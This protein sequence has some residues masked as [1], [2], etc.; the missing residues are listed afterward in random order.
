LAQFYNAIYFM[1]ADAS[2]ATAVHIYDAGAKS[3]STQSVAASTFDPTSFN[4]ILDHDT[5][6]FY[7]LSKGE[8]FFLRME[9]LVKANDT[10]LSWVDVGK[11][12]LPD[13]YEPVM[14]LAENHIHFLDVPNIPAGD[15]NIFV[16][17]CK[18]YLAL[19]SLNILFTHA[20]TVSWYQPDPQSYPLPDG[21]TFPKTHGQATSFFQKEGVQQE[22]AFIPD[23]GSATYVINVDTNTTQKLPGPSTKDAAAQYVAG[24]TSLVQVD[25]QGAVSFL[26]YKQGDAST[27]AQASW[28]SVAN[29]AAAVP[30]GTAT[31]SP[32]SNSSSTHNGTSSSSGSNTTSAGGPAPSGNSSSSGGSGHASGAM[33]MNLPVSIAVA[34]SGILCSIAALL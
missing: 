22:F 9:A 1:N 8:L 19:S 10:A 4:A 7:A 2:D 30:A 32:G 34:V 14:A 20:S 5:N 31:S 29:L 28:T 24:I 6:V 3:W 21:S 18:L 17:H 25:S 13:G 23:D 16:I 11:S 15:A 26:P 27:N 33:S 12:P